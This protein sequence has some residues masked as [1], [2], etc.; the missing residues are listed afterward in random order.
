VFTQAASSAERLDWSEMKQ[1]NY[2][3]VGWL[4][5]TYKNKSIGEAMTALA[6]VLAFSSTPL[7]AQD[8]ATQ[9]PATLE[10][11]KAPVAAEATLTPPPS[12][13]PIE[14]ARQAGTT[15]V[16]SA[17]P[18]SEFEQL[19]SDAMAD[20]TVPFVIAGAAGLGILALLGTGILT[21]RRKVRR[22]REDLEAKHRLLEKAA[23]SI[24]PLE[25]D[26]S[27]EVGPAY[28]RITPKHDPVPLKNA[29]VTKLPTGFDLSRFGPNVQAAYLG[30]TADNP[31]LSL[32]YR[33]RRAMALDQQ[34]RRRAEK[35][36]APVQAGAKPELRSGDFMFRRHE[37]L[38][39]REVE[40]SG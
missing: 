34:A 8:T 18:P 11:A 13:S 29:P 3:K 5:M 35:A 6:A 24:P 10:T 16:A 15:A 12:V 2:V 28:A 26:R 25:L 1:P 22:E 23:T 33:L 7:S 40:R 20:E 4:V 19:M 39:E 32:K 30:P 37:S 9:P 38:R 21:R 36:P 14:R 27:N 17:P 31:S